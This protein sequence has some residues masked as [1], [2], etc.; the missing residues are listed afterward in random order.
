M[1]FIYWSPFV[2][3][4][5]LFNLRHQGAK[6]WN[7]VDEELKLLSLNQFKKNWR[8]NTCFNININLLLYA[9]FTI[10]Q[11]LYYCVLILCVLIL[12]NTVIVNSCGKLLNRHWWNIRSFACSSAFLFMPCQVCF[13]F[14]CFCLFMCVCFSIPVEFH[15]VHDLPFTILYYNYNNGCLDSSPSGYYR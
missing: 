12:C 2:V 1:L 14:F 15:L 4:Y 3:N 5:G 11:R 8:K 9:L 7:S 10:I 13:L 6:I